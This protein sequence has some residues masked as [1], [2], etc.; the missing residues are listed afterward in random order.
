V[1]VRVSELHSGTSI[2]FAV[3]PISFAK[4]FNNYNKVAEIGT[5]G[6]YFQEDK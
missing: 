3:K 5:S 4:L 6:K 1:L 2:F